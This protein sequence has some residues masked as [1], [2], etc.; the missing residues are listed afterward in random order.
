MMEIFVDAVSDGF[1]AISP[2]DIPDTFTDPFRYVPCKAVETAAG[3]VMKRIDE[4][5][6]LSSIF[7][8]GKMLGVL[9]VEDE[10][11]KLGFISGFSGN[12]G[13]RSIIEGFVP[14]IYDLTSPEGHYKVMEKEISS[15]NEEIASE[16]DSAELG[17]LRKELVSCRE[18]AFSEIERMKREMA[19]SRNARN[20]ARL[21]GLDTGSEEEMA[22]QSQHEK[23]SLRRLKKRW[24]E[25]ICNLEIEVKA[26][27]D[28]INALK[29]RRKAMS[30]ELQKWIFRQYIVHNANGESSA[31]QDIF[32]SSGCVP[33]GGTGECAAPKMLEYAYRNRL[34]PLAM[35][36]FWYGKSPGTA[37]RVHGHFYPSCTS[38]CGPLLGYMMQGL[39]K[40][41]GKSCNCRPIIMHM[42]ES[43]I[44][45]CKP[46]GM[47]SVPGLDGK[48]SL[49]EWLEA[50]TGGEVFC[51][52]RLDM[53][54]SG[55]IVFA[56][57]GEAQAVLRSQFEDRKVS[58]TYIARLCRPDRGVCHDDSTTE[59][60]AR[61]EGIISL[62]LSPDYD[63]RPRQKVDM[64]DGKEAV[65]SY[66][67]LKEYPDG[68]SDVEF[69]PLTGRTHQL[70][71]HS[72]HPLGLGR[73]IVGDLLYGG[74]SATDTIPHAPRLHLHAK[75]L[76]FT[77]PTNGC[78][79]TFG[80]GQLG[81]HPVPMDEP[82]QK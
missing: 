65:T 10:G 66:R 8:E 32:A 11:G 3:I 28:R 57:T 18:T 79:L 4:S 48:P 73:P 14:P 60:P 50:E 34:K 63:E 9:I 46:G 56:R 15:L 26:F 61:N 51:V 36:E 13:G 20:E 80:S 81:F 72:A 17:R 27:T 70:R 78:R 23:A 54:T 39:H 31:I 29:A 6:T 58:K 2:S 68:T 77:H 12:A 71:V 22:R 1:P 74:Y 55:V 7:R 25:K 49:Q 53:D 75:A 5:E 59:K 76:T 33:P 52:H 82:A 62:P 42:D 44:V 38:K 37:V 43:I 69:R 19:V 16:T 35:G 30:D 67:I 24:E 64:T 41:K 47:P 45:A 21:A 40:E